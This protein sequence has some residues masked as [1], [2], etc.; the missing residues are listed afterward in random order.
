MRVRSLRW[1]MVFGIAAIAFGA[2]GYSVSHAQ[3]AEALPEEEVVASVDEAAP[4]GWTGSG[5]HPGKALFDAHCRLCHAISERQLTG[6]G[7]LGV[8]QRVEAGPAHE[9]KSVVQRLLEYIKNARQGG[10]ENYS[11]DPYFKSVQESVAGAGVQMSDRGGLPEDVTDRQILDV[12]HY[13][14]TVRDIEFDEAQYWREYKLGHALVAGDSPFQWG[15]PSCSGCHSVGADIQGADIGPNIAHTYVL[16]RARG[17]DERNNF[18]D[19]LY[20]ILSGKDAPKAHHF[21]R[22]EEG[23]GPPTEAELKVMATYF[24]QAA[25]ETGT[26]HSSNYLPI[27]ALLFAALCIIALEP[28]IVNILFAKEHGEYIDGPYKED[29]HHGHEEGVHEHH[30]EKKAEEKKE[31]KS[32][33]GEAK[34]EEPNAEDK[35]AEEVK[36]E[37]KADVP[38]EEP[39]AESKDTEYSPKPEEAKA[40]EKP[41]DKSEEAK[42]EGEDKKEDN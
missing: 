30:A 37:P 21:Y 2:I 23:S 22:D 28:G 17:K 16:M 34:A 19:G 35:P 36:E 27:F 32:D 15:A 13:F 29:D 12:I 8:G 9:G 5:D 42:P 11:P 18:T 20:E 25:R 14:L 26:E 41:E 33:A 1:L 4:P 6:P 24:E 39:K 31:E 10:P 40:E 7:L 3:V 38:A